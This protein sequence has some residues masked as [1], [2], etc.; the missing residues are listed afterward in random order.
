MTNSTDQRYN[1]LRATLARL[2]GRFRGQEAAQ[3][4]P[5]AACLGL[6]ASAVLAVAWRLEPRLSLPSLL[7]ACAGLVAAALL[8]STLYTLVRPRDLLATA[9]HADHLLL[10][11]ERLS[12]ALEAAG[13]PPAKASREQVVLWDAQLDD[14]LSHVKHI[15]PKRDVPITW[16][17]WMLAPVA[18]TLVLF[19]A[20]L[21]TPGLPGNPLDNA[22]R[23]QLATEQQKI[24]ALKQAVQSQPRVADDPELKELLKQLSDLSKDLSSGNLTREEALARMSQAESQLQKALDPQAA[25]QREA[26]DQLAK[27]LANSNSPT[28]R[29]VGD[30][31]KSGDPNK[32]AEQLKKAADDAASM[33]PEERK[34]LAQ[35]LRQARDQTVALDP[36]LAQRLNEAADALDSNDTKAAQDALNNVTQQVQDTG[37]HLATQQRIQQALAQIQQSKSNVAQ[38][39]QLSGTAVAGGTPLPAGTALALG[40]PVSGTPL[41]AGSFIAGTPVA[42][43]SP[44]Q[45]RPA[46]TG[47]PV[48]VQT[49]PGRG[50]PI[51]V[52]G[53]GQPAAGSGNGQGQGQGQT[54]GQGNSGSN[55]GVGHTEPVYA[56][57]SSVNAPLTPVALQGQNNPNGEQ[58]T[59]M[60]NS[61]VN[62]TNPAL[63]PYDQVYNQ[64]K[65]QAG[66]ALNS[67]YIPQ[68]YK[69]LVRDYFN[70]IEPQSGP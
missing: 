66:N 58:S 16:D 1:D 2:Q 45:G 41:A 6:G 36:Q 39:G 5:I 51:A 35:A 60:A 47:T 56:P 29:E 4:A 20:V 46:Q 21:A 42:L 23:Q 33:S 67:D 70:H 19:F 69:D 37:Q 15:S 54:G 9:R 27:Q 44:V 12:T 63:V 64:Y 49:T 25:A 59:G 57:P 43:G 40:T 68:G 32:A 65:E 34:A 18:A 10:L 30:A 52:Q 26:L 55:W 53:Q 62:T 48:L 7:L 17:R 24:D 11:D 31:L 13:H 28:A 61:N 14:A 50:T 8:A 3:F 22:V 38:A